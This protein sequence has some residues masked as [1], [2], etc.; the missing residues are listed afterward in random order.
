MMRSDHQVGEVIR[1]RLMTPGRDE[2][3]D[4]LEE[5]MK[6]EPLAGHVHQL[7]VALKDDGVDADFRSVEELLKCQAVQRVEPG[8]GRVHRV[9]VERAKLTG[10][11]RDHHTH[12]A[13]QRPRLEHHGVADGVRLTQSLLQAPY[14]SESHPGN[15]CRPQQPS[16]RQLVAA[17]A[18]SRGGHVGQPKA[19]RHLGSYLQQGLVP[20]EHACPAR[21]FG[22]ALCHRPGQR[23]HTGVRHTAVSGQVTTLPGGL[24][25]GDKERLAAG[26]DSGEGVL[27]VRSPAAADDDD[28]LRSGQINR[29]AAKVEVADRPA[30]PGIDLGG[31]ARTEAEPG[32]GVLV[33][34]DV[35]QGLADKGNTLGVRS[36]VP[37]QLRVGRRDTARPGRW[38]RYEQPAAA[39]RGHLFS[40]GVYGVGQRRARL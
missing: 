29:R 11:L 33:T 7:Y 1:P 12:A 2:V 6:A 39:P 8:V 36:A 35:V 31:A 32:T 34:W 17:V 37:A 5:W 21:G 19:P 28:P 27:P 40:Y 16:G 18:H 10:V 25:G 23:I 30:D 14:M 22:D 15:T 20:G 13:R 26:C 9:V 24:R 4:L 3:T 38:G